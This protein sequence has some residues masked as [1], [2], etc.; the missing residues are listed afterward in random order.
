MGALDSWNSVRMCR[1]AFKSFKDSYW[2]FRTSDLQIS[3]VN[4]LCRDAGRSWAH[5]SAWVPTSAGTRRRECVQRAS[6]ITL[7]LNMYRHHRPMT[8]TQ[9][10]MIASNIFIGNT[11]TNGPVLF[12][13]MPGIVVWIQWDASLQQAVGDWTVI[14]TVSLRHFSFSQIDSLTLLALL[15]RD[16]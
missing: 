1:I 8:W 14:L 11:E 16:P 9:C 4:H 5:V 3:S 12:Y 13:R 6:F 7:R 10:R 2:W 15:F